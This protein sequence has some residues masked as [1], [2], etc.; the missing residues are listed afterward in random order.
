MVDQ[1]KQVQAGDDFVALPDRFEIHE[2]SIMERFCF[3]CDE[4][5]QNALL[6]A[7][8]GK[9]AFRQR[10]AAHRDAIE[11]TSPYTTALEQISAEAK[12]DGVFG[13]P[14]LIYQGQK[15]WGNDRIEWLVESIRKA[16]S[17]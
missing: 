3:V 13:F 17:A 4:P 12:A 6:Q 14:F 1:A 9:G 7:I 11:E 5:V 10:E 15:F 8:A 2:H 16:S